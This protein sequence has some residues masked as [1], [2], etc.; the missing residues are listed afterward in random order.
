MIQIGPEKM[1]RIMSKLD[2][3]AETQVTWTEFLTYLTNEGKRREVV[4]DA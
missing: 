2:H 3:K 4:N 1:E